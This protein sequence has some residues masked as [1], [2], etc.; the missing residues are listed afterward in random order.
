[1]RYRFILTTILRVIISIAMHS[2]DETLY[3]P[4]AIKSCNYCIIQ[5]YSHRTEAPLMT[6]AIAAG[7]QH[8]LL[9]ASPVQ[10][11]SLYK[12]FLMRAFVYTCYIHEPPVCF[13][14]TDAS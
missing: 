9:S 3:R 14:Y 4:T 6:A 5:R 7:Q 10:I 13:R 11:E 8:F 1:M 12:K 2:L